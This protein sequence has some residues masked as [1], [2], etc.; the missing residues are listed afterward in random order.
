VTTL[1][2]IDLLKWVESALSK[3]SE[4]DI[5][6][7]STDSLFRKSPASGTQQTMERVILPLIV[8]P[9]YTLIAAS[10]NRSD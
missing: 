6:A 5:Q 1:K 10:R 7:G 8:R 3:F 4:A 9:L 2:R